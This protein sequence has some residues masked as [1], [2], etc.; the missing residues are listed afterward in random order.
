MTKLQRNRR[1]T[2]KLS[3]AQIFLACILSLR[4]GGFLSSLEVLSVST[5][6]LS[7]HKPAFHWRGWAGTNRSR[8]PTEMQ[9]FYSGCI[10]RW[11]FLIRLYFQV[12]IF[13]Q[14]VFPGEIFNQDVF[15][16]GDFYSGCI[17]RWGFLIRLYFQVGIFNQVVFP[18]GDF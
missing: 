1:K 3:P 6:R 2:I 10:S 18:G 15:P 7:W 13:Y 5:W 11:G 14:V 4:P 8:S 12:G 9:H 16:G 17:S